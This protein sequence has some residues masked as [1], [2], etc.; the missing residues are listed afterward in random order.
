V[1]KLIENKECCTGSEYKG[2]SIFRLII[3][4]EINKHNLKLAKPNLKMAACAICT[5]AF[6]ANNLRIKCSDCKNDFHGACV[7]MSK[8][9]IEYMTSEGNVWRCDPCAKSRRSSLRLESSL[10]EGNVTLQDIMEAINQLKLQQ[11]ESVRDFNASHEALHSQIEE[12]TK[13]LKEQNESFTRYISVI[14]ELAKENKFLKERV[15]QLEERLEDAEQY[16][17]RNCVEICGVPVTGSD[18]LNTV[19]SVGKALDMEI[20]DS[21]IDA[22]HTLGTKLG[23]Q[24]PPS[25]IVK[26]VRRLDAEKLLTKR[27]A[28]KDFST[29]HLGLASDRPVYVN[30]SLTPT[31]RRLLALVRDAKRRGC[32]KW[33]WVRGGKILY[34]KEDSGPVTIVKT[35]ADIPK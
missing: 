34:R 20:E 35:Q 33:V 32:C 21:M 9:D 10:T 1:I 7:K 12:N 8:N 29:R 30:E 14:E 18:V 17:R 22:C 4:K 25:I 11:K 26:F 23:S 19:K 31:K 13:A 5:K 27:R 6:K 24:G 3:P 2:S 28:K 15:Q 16:S